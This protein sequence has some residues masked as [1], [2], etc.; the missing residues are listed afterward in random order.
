VLGHADER[1]DEK[2][3]LMLTKAR[4]A[5]V[6]QALIQ[7]GIAASRLRSQGYGVYCPI[8]NRHQADA[9]ERNRRVEFKV[10]STTEG[11]AGVELG[12]QTAREKGVQDPKP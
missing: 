1:G 9:W 12:C 6:V 11:A 5:S 7:R 8:D 3:N 2:M 4:A 10:I